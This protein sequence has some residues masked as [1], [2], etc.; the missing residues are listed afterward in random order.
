MRIDEVVKTQQVDEVVGGLA[1]M[2]GQAVAR[3]GLG[4]AVGQAASDIKQG[5][6]QSSV[7]QALSKA[8][9]VQQQAKMQAQSQ[10]VSA[11]AQK[12]WNNRVLQLMQANQGQPIADDEYNDHLKDFTQ[13][14]MLGGRQ[15]DNLDQNSQ[16][17][18]D[19][20]IDAV[21]KNRNSKTA[22]PQAFQQLA[23]A[24]LSSRLDPAKVQTGQAASTGTATA[25]PQQVQTAVNNLAQKLGPS[26][27]TVLASGIQTAAGVAQVRS[28]GNAATDALINALGIKTV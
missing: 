12:Q 28:T 4:Q 10:A 26:F 21:M 14:T 6:Q 17:R 11:A 9:D 24:A 5:F 20:A 2:A 1:R 8:G 7:G 19:Q 27:N 15:I 3:S 23:N 22:M 16:A 25:S 18:I 13:K